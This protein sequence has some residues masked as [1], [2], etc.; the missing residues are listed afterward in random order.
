LNV[1]IDEAIIM[2]R[3]IR[4]DIDHLFDI[5]G[6]LEDGGYSI[7]ELVF[8]IIEDCNLIDIDEYVKKTAYDS[9]NRELEGMLQA[10]LGRKAIAAMREREHTHR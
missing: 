6:T 5:L 4:V 1:H 7:P 9:T 10:H 3:I 2:G 8:E